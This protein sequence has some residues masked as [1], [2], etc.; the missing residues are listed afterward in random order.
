MRMCIKEKI[1]CGR[2]L[3]ICINEKIISGR[4][5]CAAKKVLQFLL[6]L[7]PTFLCS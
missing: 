3:R 5:H 6:N 2:K 7:Y 1:I 4:R